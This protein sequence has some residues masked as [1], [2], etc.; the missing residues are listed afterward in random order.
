MTKRKTR[1]KTKNKI[2]NKKT[3]VAG[4]MR[5]QREVLSLAV[6][7]TRGGRASPKK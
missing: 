4:I 1:I 3:G 6:G 7:C 2:K 5:V